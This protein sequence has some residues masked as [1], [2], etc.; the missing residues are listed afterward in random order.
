MSQ[1][2]IFFQA[3]LMFFKLLNAFSSDRFL[4]SVPASATSS[5]HSHLKSSVA[6]SNGLLT[7]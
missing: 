7:W 4:P 3:S 2:V 5:P 1:A 6:L